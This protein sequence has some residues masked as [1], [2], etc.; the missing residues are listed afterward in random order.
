MTNRSTT[1]PSRWVRFLLALG[2]MVGVFSLSMA[3]LPF[4]AIRGYLDSLSGDGS[5]D[6]YT[7]R[8]HH[9]LQMAWL[10]IGV[11]SLVLSAGM[12]L[13]RSRWE[14]GAMAYGERFRS[15]RQLLRSEWSAMF[16]GH[17]WLLFALLLLGIALR[18]PYLD[19]PMRYDES[20]SYL[21]YSSQPWFVTI[22][23]YRD[24]NNHVGHNLLV[25]VFV[26]IFGD[27]P[28]VIRLPAF[29]AGVLLIPAT[30]LL[31]RSFGCGSSG[32][33]F[34]A[35]FVTVS[36]P[37]IEYST[38]AR[39]YTL[40]TLA[41]ALSWSLAAVLA[42][43]HNRAAWGGLLLIGALG[44]W[45]IP[46]MAYPLVMIWSWLALVCLG[47]RSS[48]VEQVRWLGTLTCAGG[49]VLLLA[50]LFY[51]P[52]LL[53]S[54]PKALLANPYVQPKTFAEI[55]SEWPTSMGESALFLTRDLGLPGIGLLAVGMIWALI[56]SAN[57]LRSLYRLATVSLFVCLGLVILQRV[58]PPPR[59]WTFLIPL[60]AVGA[61]RGIELLL[62][63]LRGSFS[64]RLGW[65]VAVF[66][67][68][69]WPAYRMI[70][71]DSVRHSPQTGQLQDA[72]EIVHFL[73]QTLRDREP[74]ITVCP[75]SAPVKYYALREGM[76]MHHFDWP[77]T[78]RTRDDI[79]L[80]IQAH[81]MPQTVESILEALGLTETFQAGKFRVIKEFPSATIYRLEPTDPP[82][83]P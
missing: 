41:T 27:S 2:V 33:I 21:E 17:G 54:G 74:V 55:A 75:S 34:S 16:Q 31:S 20:H 4:D 11:I 67:C 6:P 81:T 13:G 50:G 77:G 51:L 9:R 49:G 10:G 66:V 58:I 1:R 36:S 28:S 71:Y 15:D 45:V 18:M 82:G 79:A 62:N 14:S 25:N 26:R 7:P 63:H 42:R 37:L 80:L 23:R 12:W 19:Q 76:D 48:R 78:T 30:F 22:S 60:G 73:Q 46:V 47:S 65:S 56:D 5:A 61:S 72:Q 70:H 32:A 40:V 53:V 59:V 43:R 68:G 52:V 3:F 24:P 64:S 57:E 44:L 35:W 8:L 69:I 29:L 39:G 83:S 38:N